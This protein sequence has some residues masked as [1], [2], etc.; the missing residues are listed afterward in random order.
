[1]YNRRAT[2]RTCKHCGQLFKSSAGA[3]KYCSLLCRVRAGVVVDNNDCM[4]WNGPDSIKVV[5]ERG[6]QVAH[7]LWTG[8]G[9]GAIPRG[10]W[11]A[12][13]CDCGKCINPEHRELVRRKPEVR[14]IGDGRSSLNTV[15]VKEIK[16]A[17]KVVTNKTLAEKY[18]VNQTTI[19]NIR[20]GKTWAHVV[21]TIDDWNRR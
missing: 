3:A 14:K 11:L 10:A 5:G 17:P 12:V 13:K 15:Q 8:A 4:I 9:K 2:E 20:S 7:I 1:M 6:V 18:G 16:M 21:V 19:S